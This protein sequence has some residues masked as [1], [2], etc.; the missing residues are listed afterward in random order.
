MTNPHKHISLFIIVILI[1]GVLVTIS[2]FTKPQPNPQAQY[3]PYFDVSTQEYRNFYLPPNPR[4]QTVETSCLSANQE[5]TCSDLNHATNCVWNWNPPPLVGGVCTS[6]GFT[7]SSFNRPGQTPEVGCASHPLCTIAVTSPGQGHCSYLSIVPEWLQMFMSATTPQCS[8]TDAISCG[9][10]GKDC[11]WTQTT[12]PIMQCVER[13]SPLALPSAQPTQAQLCERAH[14]NSAAWNP[15]T[16]VYES[17]S[18]YTDPTKVAEVCGSTRGCYMNNGTCEFGS[19]PQV[20]IIN[21]SS[22][23]PPPPSPPSSNPPSQSNNLCGGLTIRQSECN[24]VPRY[25][26]HAGGRSDAACSWDTTNGCVP[27]CGNANTG[28]ATTNEKMQACQ[29]PPYSNYGCM[30]NFQ[31]NNC[32][33]PA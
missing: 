14:Y 25:V 32:Q 17:I 5:D 27:A 4:F 9:L 15:V 3:V 16:R 2:A 30:W 33:N 24:D 6:R 19:N 26:I 8:G 20:N 11:H 31:N 1:I 28:R 10:S 12:P 18:R 29:N 22:P 23:P 13:T 7:C 21:T